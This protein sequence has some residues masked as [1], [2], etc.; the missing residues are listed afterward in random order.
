[1]VIARTKL[2][3]PP[4]P[5]GVA[6]SE[7]L[8]ERLAARTEHARL[9]LIRANGG[10]GKTT[11][12]RA[13]AEATGRP[14]GWCRLDHH[15][16]V[17]SVIELV[18]AALAQADGRLDGLVELG[19]SV[20]R[21]DA[22]G[23]AT[24]IANAAA[25]VR[26]VVVV[27]DDAHQPEDPAVA[28]F[29]AALIDVAPPSLH[30]VVTTRTE[31]AG[32][33]GARRVALG[34]VVAVDAEV[35]RVDA[36]VARRI[37]EPLGW[38]ASDEQLV[39]L[40]ERTGGW[41]LG[42][43]LIASLGHDDVDADDLVQRYLAEEVLG[44]RDAHDVAALEALAVVDDLD[45]EVVAAITGTSDPGGWLDRLA[46]DLPL[47]VS[48]LGA[49]RLRLHDVLREA[50][51]ARLQAE[52]DRFAE[53]N[54]RAASVAATWPV[55][56][57]HLLTAGAHEHAAQVLARAARDHFPR[58]TTLGQVADRAARLPA[59]V[60]SRHP[61]LRVVQ[62]VV[63]TQQRAAS[64]ALAVL[65]TVLPSIDDDDLLARWAALRHGMLVT[66]DV[67]GWT[68]RLLELE[69]EP[70]FVD[71]PPAV[72]VDHAV[73]LAHAMVFA[74]DDGEAARRHEH[75][76]AIARHSRHSAAV[77]VLAQHQS[78]FL[79]QVPGGVARIDAWARW[80]GREVS[81]PS[82]V[83][84]LGCHA[85]QASVAFYRG[86][87]DTALAEVVAASA[88]SERHRL[89]FVRTLLDWVLA[90]VWLTRGDLAPAA[91]LLD[92]R[93]RAGG[94]LAAHFVALAA[95][96]RTAQGDLDELD[97]LAAVPVS[98]PSGPHQT[99]G[100]AAW[101]VARAERARVRG[102]PDE[103][104]DILEAVTARLGPLVVVP[105][106]GRLGLDLAV[107]LHEAGRD[108]DAVD[109]LG[110]EVELLA[111]RDLLGVVAS[112]GQALTPVV[113]RALAVRGP[114]AEL[115]AVRAIVE[116]DA[117]PSP[118]A[119]RD[120][121]ELSTREV[122]ILRLVAAGCSNR[123]IADRLYISV[124]TVKTHVRNLLAKLGVANRAAAARQAAGLGLGGAADRP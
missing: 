42:I 47:L 94:P 108:R 87:L 15:D 26:G 103:A 85:Q 53:A 9:T 27:V 12:A 68:G 114:R 23:A 29:L 122:E 104:V 95:R 36:E 107:A 41:V 96:V 32:L 119:V 98:D 35:L 115:R 55:A 25:E 37:L 64:E 90:S 93:R 97:A 116:N 57:D 106:V 75:A 113:D 81:E 7:G 123:D 60:L 18:V 105:G 88:L 51:L 40:V 82:G 112:H 80:V 111:Q 100:W 8:V 45:E 120:D 124:N 69:Q 10:A 30:L 83:I 20:G 34:D 39:R 58:P 13:V 86:D 77:E 16:D 28:G 59:D 4:L 73:A 118:V 71:L 46:R 56:V 92:D 84:R 65:E 74:G 33:G 117:R 22:I 17:A 5:S 43:R 66:R 3:A 38:E 110:R 52:P 67:A 121:T 61:W 24:I 1:M 91:A 76:T 2:I 14:W 19:Q 49:G 78:P 31:L 62:G 63:L 79:A 109:L 89:V 11:L 6:W 101:Q 50:L 54:A 72:R 21:T 48:R 44:P 99:T 102:R 70:G